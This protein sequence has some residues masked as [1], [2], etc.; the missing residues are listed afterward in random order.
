MRP[1]KNTMRPSIRS[2]GVLAS[3]SSDRTA[4]TSASTPSGAVATDPP[5]ATAIS[6]CGQGATNL[7]LRFATNPV[8]HLDRLGVHV[9]EAEH[10]ELGEG[11]GDGTGVS[12][13]AGEPLTHFG[14]ERTQALVRGVVRQCALTHRFARDRGSTA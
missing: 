6:G 14:R 1:V 8:R 3:S 13:R 5:R 11:P 4:T 10:F 12:G 7:H 2:R 9:L